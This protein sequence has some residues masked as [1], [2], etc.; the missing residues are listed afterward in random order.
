MRCVK[1]DGSKADAPRDGE[2]GVG[3][4]GNCESGDSSETAGETR[5]L[6][7]VR[8]RV[9]RAVLITSASERFATPDLLFKW[10]K[11]R[12]PICVEWS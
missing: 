1:R 5:E 6:V 9:E 12:R 3:K 8:S 2:A 7:V 4:K 10:N 11:T